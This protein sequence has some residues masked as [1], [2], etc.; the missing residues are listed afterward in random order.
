MG[1]V[2]RSADA[3]G[4]E[5]ILLGGICPVPP[6]RDIQKAALGATETVD[7]EHCPDLATKLLDMQADG[8]Q[9]LGIEQ[10]NESI[11]LDLFNNS[12]PQKT[13]LVL[14]NEV[15]GVSKEIL[16]ICDKHLE[17]KQ[18]GH[19]KSLNISV[20]AGIVMHEFRTRARNS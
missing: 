14:G 5:K 9:I 13:V 19:K 1:S 15:K 12:S 17:I 11:T 16:E 6:H 20:C 2:F 18:Y 8:W 10:T 7:Y 4:I 3:F